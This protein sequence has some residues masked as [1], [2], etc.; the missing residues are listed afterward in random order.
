[1][2]IEPIYDMAL[3]KETMKK[4]YIWPYIHDDMVDLDSFEPFEPIDDVAQYLGVFNEGMYCGFF[5]IVR[6]NSITYEIHTVLKKCCR[7]EKAVLAAKAVISWIFDNTDCARLITQIPEDNIPAERLAINAG[8]SIYGINPDSFK[9][10]NV[11]K[12]VKLYGI[13]KG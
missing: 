6:Q 11:I 12:S 10:N 4:P 7:G 8:M 9:I 13:T 3:I 1:M 2:I 5:L